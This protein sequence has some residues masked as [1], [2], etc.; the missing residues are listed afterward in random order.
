MDPRRVAGVVHGREVVIPAWL[1][2]RDAEWLKQR[3]GFL[4]GMGN[5][6]GYAQGGYVDSRVYDQR[7]YQTSSGGGSSQ[8]VSFAPAMVQIQDPWGGIQEVVL[9][10]VDDRMSDHAAASSARAHQ[11]YKYGV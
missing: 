6:R 11:T 1:V 3:Y 7:V 4:P 10:V 8:R 9:Q 2:R 5:V